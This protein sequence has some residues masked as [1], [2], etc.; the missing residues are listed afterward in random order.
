VKEVDG[1]AA[2]VNW[3]S[4]AR[5]TF[6]YIFSPSCIWCQR[7]LQNI[8]ALSGTQGSAYRFIGLSLSSNGLKK[9]VEENE[10]K[11]PVYT[12]ASDANG[13]EIKLHATPQTLIVSP[14]GRVDEAWLGAYTGRMQGEIERK[15]GV[16]LP[17][18]PSVSASSSSVTHS[19]Y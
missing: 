9:Y 8:K 11:F 3:A 1:A 14:N 5:P 13:R 4:D 18:L 15:L 17:G 19:I 2:F 12:S 16:H 6:V 10:L 7:N